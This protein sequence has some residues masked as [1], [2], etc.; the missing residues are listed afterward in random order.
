MPGMPR[1]S[2]LSKLGFMGV[3]CLGCTTRSDHTRHWVTDHPRRKLSRP[4][5]RGMEIW[6]TLRV[7]HIPT[8]PAATTD[9]GLTRRYTN[10]SLGTKD[11]SGQV[12]VGTFYDQIDSQV[13]G[14]KRAANFPGVRGN[15]R[16]AVGIRRGRGGIGGLG[17]K[18]ETPGLRQFAV[19]L[20]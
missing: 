16:R 15:F 19:V 20:Q 6:K 17:A 1:V 10:P 9:N 3:A 5:N 12:P 14:Q 2:D 11:R 18:Y 7:P 13:S 8:P 4:S